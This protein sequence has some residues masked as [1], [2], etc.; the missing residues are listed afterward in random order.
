MIAL[1]YFCL[2]EGG[3]FNKRGCLTRGGVMMSRVMMSHD[4][5]AWH[6]KIAWQK[7]SVKIVLKACILKNNYIQNNLDISNIF[8]RA[9]PIANIK[10]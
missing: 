10:K 6:D 4:K 9:L 1:F 7:N 3:L 2:I 8:C 5:F